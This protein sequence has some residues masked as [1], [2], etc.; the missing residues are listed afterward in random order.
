MKDAYGN[1]NYSIENADWSFEIE[2]AKLAV[3]KVNKMKPKPRF[4]VIC[5]DLTNE[6]PSKLT[7]LNSVL[8]C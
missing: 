6:F 3:E 1:P 7:D 4:F 8:V 5:G 2:V